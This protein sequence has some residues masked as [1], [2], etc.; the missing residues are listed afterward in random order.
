L[1]KLI[2]PVGGDPF[3]ADGFSPAS[4]AAI[5]LFNQ[6][7]EQWLA[8]ADPAMRPKLREFATALQNRWLARQ[9]ERMVDEP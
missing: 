9:T 7:L 2:D 3:K 5:A 6:H 8:D 4:F 1:T